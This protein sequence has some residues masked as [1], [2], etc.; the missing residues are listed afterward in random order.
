MTFGYVKDERWRPLAE[1][2]TNHYLCEIK[3]YLISKQN[4]DYNPS[5]TT[6]IIILLEDEV[7]KLK[8]DIFKFTL[9]YR[10]DLTLTACGYALEKFQQMAQRYRDEND[11]VK[12]LE[13]EK[14]QYCNDFC[15]EY[16]QTAKEKIAARQCCELIETAIE[17]RVM[18]NLCL[19]VVQ[20]WKMIK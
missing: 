13:R 15:D 3:K 12:C 8:S 2:E 14:L 16:F 17:K 19:T 10:M 1:L 20:K 5:F 9:E 7:E 6:E 4:K 18:K 11:P